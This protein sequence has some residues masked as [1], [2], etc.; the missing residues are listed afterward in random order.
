M[1]STAPPDRLFAEYEPLQPMTRGQ[2]YPVQIAIRRPDRPDVPVVTRPGGPGPTTLEV[3][4]ACEVAVDLVGDDAWRI[5][6][7]SPPTA[8]LCTAFGRAIW[9]WN[10]TPLADGAR[11]LTFRLTYPDGFVYTEAL[12]VTVVVEEVL[13]GAAERTGG[14]H[15]TGG[16]GLVI[17]VLAALGGGI[18]IAAVLLVLRSRRRGTAT[19]AGLLAP[20]TG[21]SPISGRPRVFISYARVD[22]DVVGRIERSLES[23][24]FDTWRDVDDIAGGDAWRKAIT[25]GIAHSAAVVLCVSSASVRSTSVAREIALADE[26]RKAIIPILL[27]GEVD[28]GGSL[29]YIL[30]ETHHIDLRVQPFAAAMSQLATAIAAVIARIE[31]PVATEADAPAPHAPAPGAPL[32]PPNP[33][34]S[35]P[36]AR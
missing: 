29:R 36:P 13:A 24:G 30:A 3:P 23:H 12:P 26:A 2:T 27:E 9:T 19:R 31:P 5:E 17:G 28:L 7:L 16:R 33:V 4:G 21:P 14:T 32:P 25:E 6:A 22:D 35:P 1:P 8:P 10:V 34:V 20:A 11:S 18:G 15:G